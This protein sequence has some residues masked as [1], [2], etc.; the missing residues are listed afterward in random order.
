[1]SEPRHRSARKHFDKLLLE[2]PD[3]EHLV[4]H[5]NEQGGTVSGL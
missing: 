3:P 2:E 4:E 5:T 1:M